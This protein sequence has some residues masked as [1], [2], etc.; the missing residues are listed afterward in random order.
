[1]VR[2]HAE[3]QGYAFVGPVTVD[4]ERDDE[5]PTGLFRVRSAAR[6]RRRRRRAGR[7]TAA[8]GHRRRRQGA[9]G[10]RSAARRTR[11]AHG[12]RPG[13]GAAPTPTCASTTPASPAS[14][15]EL[16]APAATSTI[17]DLGS[18]NGIVVDGQRVDQRGCATA[19]R[20][21]SAAPR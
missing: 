13:S 2:E 10:S 20:C 7:A 11:S 3:E 16:A 12:R 18:T 17:V 4:F 14:H 21:G 15:A 5:L 8:G 1:M 6:G 19:P 9:R